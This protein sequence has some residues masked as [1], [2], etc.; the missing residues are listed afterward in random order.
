MNL[1]KGA[2]AAAIVAA[3]V[4]LAAGPVVEEISHYR[5]GGARAAPATETFGR[6]AAPS[7]MDVARGVEQAIQRAAERVSPAV[8]NLGVVREMASGPWGGE[9]GAVPDW[10]PDELRGRMREYFDELRRR[11]ERQ[12]FRAQ[13]NGSGCIISEDGFIL[14]SEHVVRDAT[15]IVVTRTGGK[16]YR[17]RVVGADPRRDLA[18]IR[19]E[20]TGLPVAE[21]GDASGLARGQFVIALG[22]PFGFG[23]DGQASLS[24]GI[25]SATGRAIPGV[26]AELDRYYGNLI[27]TDAAVNPGNSGGPLV[28]LEG[29]VVGVNAVISSRGGT[30]EG[31]GFAVPIDKQTRG[32]IE[33]LKRGEEIVYGFL[34]IEIYEVTE[35]EESEFGAEAGR[36]AFVSSVLADTPAAKAGLKQGDIVLAIGKETVRGPDDVIQIVQATPVGEEVDLEV[37]RDGKRETFRV[38]VARRPAP[39]ALAVSAQGDLWWRGM[40]VEPLTDELREQTGLEGGQAGV[41]VREVRNSSPAAEAGVV[42]GMVIDQVGDRKVASV[43]EF[44]AATGEAEGPLFVHVVGIGVK[45]IQG[46]GGA[47]HPGAPSPEPNE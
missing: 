7:T 47:G 16:H 19:I 32:I 12:P 37:L 13:G 43:A 46:T 15:E 25:V 21:L 4:A 18:V 33:R 31:V 26:G 9:G 11:G 39:R 17:A 44:A 1:P 20:A 28:D 40:R 42:P 5:A 6:A 2:L 14:T 23:R 35:V 34:G 3:L 38:A 29:R 10:L 8:V 24:F 41:F 27:Q 30:S 22:S 36:G 45:V